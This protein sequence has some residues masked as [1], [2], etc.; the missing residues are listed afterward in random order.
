M[1]S[2]VNVKLNLNLNLNP[3]R[4]TTTTDYPKRPSNSAGW[5]KPRYSNKEIEVDVEK[6]DTNT[7]WFFLGFVRDLKEEA[8]D[9]GITRATLM[10]KSISIFSDKPQYLFTIHSTSRTSFKS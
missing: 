3:D 10:L 7:S 5:G 9:M 6:K 2:V 8:Q 4:S 1:I